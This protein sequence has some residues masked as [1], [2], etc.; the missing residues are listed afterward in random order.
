M[1]KTHID[2]IA[3][4][5]ARSLKDEFEKW[6]TLHTKW[7]SLKKRTGVFLFSVISMM[8]ASIVIIPFVLWGPGSYGEIV[9]LQFVHL[10]LR[11]AFFQSLSQ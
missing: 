1:K 3:T 2:M 7:K 10:A 4:G 11:H 9:T 5:G 6:N 8:R